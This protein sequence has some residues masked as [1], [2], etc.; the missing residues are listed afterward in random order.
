M[1]IGRAS[2]LFRHSQVVKAR[3][4]LHSSKILEFNHGPAI[5][6]AEELMYGTGSE[7]MIEHRKRIR[8]QHHIV[9]LIQ[10]YADLWSIS[11]VRSSLLTRYST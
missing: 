3:L 10:A 9:R 11:W 7:K 5:P 4:S 8:G 1:N 6:L 2:V